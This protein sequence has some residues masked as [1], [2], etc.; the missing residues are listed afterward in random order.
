[1]K[2]IQHGQPKLAFPSTKRFRCC[3]CHCVF[4]AEYGEYTS[5]SQYNEIYFQCKCPEC[6]KTANEV[7]MR[8][9]T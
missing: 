7:R 3:S 2:I 4:E 5:G 6:G 1:M 9:A 8:G